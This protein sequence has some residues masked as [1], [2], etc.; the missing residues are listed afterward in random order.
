[1]FHLQLMSYRRV[2]MGMNFQ[3]STI[4][5]NHQV[6]YLAKEYN[7]DHWLSLISRKRYF[8]WNSIHSIPWYFFYQ[9]SHANSQCH[10]QQGKKTWIKIH[11]TQQL[12][13]LIY[14]ARELLLYPV[15]QEHFLLQRTH[16]IFHVLWCLLWQSVNCTSSV[17]PSKETR[18]NAEVVKSVKKFFCTFFLFLIFNFFFIHPSFPIIVCGFSYNPP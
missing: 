11:K 4:F 14:F 10:L 6:S 2:L 17:K 15:I 3:F 7:I 8:Q 16:K 12:L 18:R 5:S 1:M 13:L 9:K